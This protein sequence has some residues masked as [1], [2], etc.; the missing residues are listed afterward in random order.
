MVDFSQILQ[1][2][3]LPIP[4][5]DRISQK[6]LFVAVIRFWFHKNA[7]NRSQTLIMKLYKAVLNKYLITITLTKLF[8]K[9]GLALGR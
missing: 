7:N 6:W 4:H 3:L 2:L 8:W 1:N 9:T 5:S